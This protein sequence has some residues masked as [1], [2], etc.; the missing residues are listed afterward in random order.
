MKIDFAYEKMNTKARFEK[1]ALGNSEMAY[2]APVTDGMFFSALKET[3]FLYAFKTGPVLFYS[4][5]H[6]TFLAHAGGCQTHNPVNNF[7][8]Q[9]QN[10]T[11]P[12]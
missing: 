5:S 7:S 9:L 6:C 4:S 11:S 10:S 1:E 3:D 8:G 12:R 2:F